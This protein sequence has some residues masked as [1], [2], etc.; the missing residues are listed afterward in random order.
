MSGSRE[1]NLVDLPFLFGTRGSG[2]CS[3]AAAAAEVTVALGTFLALALADLSL[4]LPSVSTM[5]ALKAA[6][7]AWNLS[8]SFG[9]LSVF[10]L[11][12]FA[13]FFGI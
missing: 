4:A 10:F 8:A 7:V 9:K 1:L 12:D 2:A 5:D 11:A 3:T 13:M 6:D